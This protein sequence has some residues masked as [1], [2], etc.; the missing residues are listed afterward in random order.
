LGHAIM[1]AV[2]AAL[3]LAFAHAA[4]AQKC[5]ANV[6]LATA[7][8]LLDVMTKLNSKVDNA[9]MIIRQNMIKHD[10]NVAT[11]TSVGAR[12]DTVM[13]NSAFD[14]SGF[15]AWRATNVYRNNRNSP[16]WQ[17]IGSTYD[18]GIRRNSFSCSALVKRTQNGNRDYGIFGSNNLHLVVRRSKYYMGFWGN[19]CGGRST[20][21]RNRMDHV[22]FVYDAAHTRQSIY[23]NGKEDKNCRGKRVFAHNQWLQ[24]GSWGGVRRGRARNPW[25]G[26]IRDARVYRKAF[27]YA[28]IKMMFPP[29]YDVRAYL[30][31]P[32]I[33]TSFPVH[34]GD[35][36]TLGIKGQ[37]FTASALVKRTSPANNDLAIFGSRKLHLVVRGDRYYMGFWGNDCGSSNSATKGKSLVGATDRVTFMYNKAKK[38]QSIWVNGVVVKRCGNKKVFNDNNKN[39]MDLGAWSQGTNADSNTGRNREWKGEI[40]EAVIYRK[41]FRD[42]Q[43]AKLFPGQAVSESYAWVQPEGE[44]QKVFYHGSLNTDATNVDGTSRSRTNNYEIATPGELGINGASFTM[45]ALVKRTK[46]GNQDFTVFGSDRLH[47]CVRRGKFYLGFYGDDCRSTA[48][49]ATSIVGKTQRIV[50]EYDIKTRLQKMIVDGVVA[51]TCKDKGPAGFTATRDSTIRLGQWSTNRKNRLWVGE[52]SEAV[53]YNRI[54]TDPEAAIMF[55]PGV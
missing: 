20:N 28:D 50:F 47:L 8:K 33:L 41:Y 10:E 31:P 30:Q 40:S 3:V 36:D 9:Q 19:D 12:I 1:R 46:A 18:L 27:S 44:T 21:V 51:G 52:I 29:G 13:Q 6:Q 25:I 5:D 17:R 48:A 32:G 2:T 14:G 39:M 23:V 11:I 4:S 26:E 54:F 42:N 34:L 7:T 49:A 38:Q 16:R 43:M 55:P 37:S 35:V 53:I 45:A 24:L 15:L 22:M